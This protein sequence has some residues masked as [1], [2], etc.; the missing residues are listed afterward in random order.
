MYYN[1]DEEFFSKYNKEIIPVYNYMNSN[2][3]LFSAIVVTNKTRV[4]GVD[5]SDPYLQ[6]STYYNEYPQEQNFLISVGWMETEVHYHK[7][8]VGLGETYYSYAGPEWGGNTRLTGYVK[9]GDTV[10]IV[11]HFLDVKISEEVNEIYIFPNPVKELLNINS[12]SE[13]IE[14]IE[15]INSLGISVS[16]L[17]FAN[18]KEVI[19]NLENLNNGIYYL[20]IN[21]NYIKKFIKT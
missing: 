16:K 20:K 21:D 9:D 8:E 17:N 6:S 7:Y 18:K 10:G 5:L 19:L 12:I 1:N 3:S 11:N 15:I 13:N 14:N 2:D 4:S